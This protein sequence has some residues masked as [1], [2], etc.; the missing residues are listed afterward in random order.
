[1][2]DTAAQISVSP[3]ELDQREVQNFEKA[4]EINIQRMFTNYRLLLK[5]H[6]QLLDMNKEMIGAHEEIQ[7]ETASRNIVS[8][9]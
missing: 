2:S 5:K 6:T 1:M 8:Y 3:N 9:R 4:L 7:V